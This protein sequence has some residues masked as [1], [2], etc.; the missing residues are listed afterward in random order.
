MASMRASV[1]P[2]VVMGALA[3]SAADHTV[4]YNLSARPATD[5]G[6]PVLVPVQDEE[7][8]QALAGEHRQVV[9][10]GE[11]KAS[12]IL[13]SP[14]SRTKAELYF[15]T[16][17]VAFFEFRIYHR[18]GV[19][20]YA[21]NGETPTSH[22]LSTRYAAVDCIRMTDE[23]LEVTVVDKDYGITFTETLPLDADECRVGYRVDRMMRHHPLH[24]SAMAGNA[25]QIRALLASP[26]VNPR[27]LDFEGRYAWEVAANDEC[28]SLLLQ[29]AGKPDR[30]ADI[31][32]TL[33]YLRSLKEDYAFA[34]HDLETLEKMLQTAK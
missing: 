4:E 25:H 33:A 28:R 26:K 9:R 16:F 7:E 21:R 24:E 11:P 5:Q 23:A 19:R 30:P 32:A 20:W 8:L 14:D 12:G 3:A 34:P 17:G 29:A 15:D 6:K 2:Y 31:A 10:R 18:R 22:G 13:S 1:L 27:L